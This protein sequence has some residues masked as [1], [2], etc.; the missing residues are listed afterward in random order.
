MQ[1]SLVGCTKLP[2][3]KT[4]KQNVQTQNVSMVENQSPAVQAQ[5]KIS[6][7]EGIVSVKAVNAGNDLYVA[8]KP[9]QYKRFQLKAL[10]KEISNKLQETLPSYNYH[11]SLDGKIYKLVEQLQSEI[12]KKEIDAATIVKEGKIIHSEMNS[13]T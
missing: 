5:D 12:N 2:E 7:L 10:R 4:A 13:D 1:I 6:T 8:A 3:T 11:V 9:A